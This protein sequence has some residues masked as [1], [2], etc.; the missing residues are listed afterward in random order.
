MAFHRR[1]R[2]SFV[3]ITKPKKGGW[4]AGSKKGQEI[5]PQLLQLRWL[6]SGYRWHR[7][8][9]NFGA[10]KSSRL[11]V[12]QIQH[13]SKCLCIQPMGGVPERTVSRAAFPPP[14]QAF[15]GQSRNPPSMQMSQD[16]R[17]P[18]SPVGARKK[19]SQGKW[20]QNTAKKNPLTTANV[21]RTQ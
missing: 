8:C 3:A 4:L 13:S 2:D 18:H 5:L 16:G 12:G 10:S 1:V 15:L 9:K 14:S 6:Q 11:Q 7:M 20:S 21:M 17:I 19:K